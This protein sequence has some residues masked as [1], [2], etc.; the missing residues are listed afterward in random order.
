MYCGS[1]IPC[2]AP[3]TGAAAIA[4]FSALCAV[5]CSNSSP[6]MDG[7]GKAGSS[8]SSA[9]QGGQPS[10][11]AGAASA[12]AAGSSVAG[13]PASGG[14]G[15]QA[16]AA[17][18]AGGGGNSGS[19]GAPSAAGA[20]SYPA[21]TGGGLCPEG[22][23]LCDNFEE[24]T[25]VAMNPPLLDELVP[26]WAQYKF[27]GY[28]RVDPSKPFSGKQSATMDTEAGSYRFAGLIHDTADGVAAVPLAHFGRVMVYLKAL[29]KTSQW[30]I[31][32][33]SGLLA[34]SKTELATYGI[35]GVGTRAGLSYTQRPRQVS[36]D[37]GIEL[38]AGGPENATENALATANC[39]K[40]S[41][42]A[43][44]PVAKWVCVEWNI[45]AAKKEMHLWLDQPQAEVDA[46]G[47][48][49]ACVAPAAATTAWQGPEMFTKVALDW[50]AYDSDSP[51]QQ[52]W[53]DELAIGEK[54]I[55]CPTPSASP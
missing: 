36:G 2:F 24:Y 44:F 41:D 32:E 7:A 12:G 28:P 39:T 22:A 42:T 49:A 27:H 50:E 1:P 30:T 26:N 43:D 51:Q 3:V 6:S 37:G 52:V 14:A 15:G 8:G 53:F 31:I 13:S 20:A 47:S 9:A 35:G 5:A 10:G 19:A 16:G 34:G 4:L 11:S 38:R 40:T 21:F 23:L 18:N 17:T 33:L 54:R 25:F 48:G 46:L 29:P 55:G 45:D